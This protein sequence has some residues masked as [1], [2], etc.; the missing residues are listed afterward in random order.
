[1]M[2]DLEQ[3]WQTVRPTSSVPLAFDSLW[4]QTPRDFASATSTL[5]RCTQSSPSSQRAQVMAPRLSRLVYNASSGNAWCAFDN[6]LCGSVR[7]LANIAPGPARVASL[8][9]GIDA[10][11]EG[12]H[13]NVPFTKA[14]RPKAGDEVRSPAQE[15]GAGQDADETEYAA[16]AEK[17]ESVNRAAWR[18]LP[19]S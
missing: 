16:R 15:D 14:C 3:Q 18:K 19:A 2:A 1:M 6:W 7:A 17:W 8:F 10:R 11:T 13:Q 5:S 4:H 12:K 9:H